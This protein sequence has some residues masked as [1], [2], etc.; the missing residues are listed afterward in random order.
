ML[1]RVL[2]HNDFDHRYLLSLNEIILQGERL[3]NSYKQA[4][5]R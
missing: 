3:S 1:E 2:V 5:P 4:L